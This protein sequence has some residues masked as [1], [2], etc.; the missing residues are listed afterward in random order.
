VLEGVDDY[1]GRGFA[2]TVSLRDVDGLTCL[3]LG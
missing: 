3:E 2:P 1:A